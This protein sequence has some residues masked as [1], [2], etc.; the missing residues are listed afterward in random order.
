MSEVWRGNV[1]GSTVQHRSG[2]QGVE[3]RRSRVGRRWGGA[4]MSSPQTKPDCDAAKREDAFFSVEGEIHD[5]R[6]MAS[7]AWG[8]LMTVK[9][10]QA[11]SGVGTE[12]NIPPL[13]VRTNPVRC[14]SY[15]ESGKRLGGGFPE[16]VRG[17]GGRMNVVRA[18]S[19]YRGRC[20]PHGGDP[21][22]CR[23]RDIRWERAAFG[24]PF[25][26]QG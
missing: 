18:W 2:L 16:G 14:L 1:P 15:D 6:H 20:S 9:G 5:L 7:I 8:L 4:V 19:P 10:T 26:V 22:D 12:L 13:G 3:G 17:G 25:F 21:G 11:A 23:G 24:R